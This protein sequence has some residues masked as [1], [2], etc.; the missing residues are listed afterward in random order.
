MKRS[1]PRIALAAIALMALPAA[2][3][4]QE[5]PDYVDSSRAWHA[6][7]F[8]ENG[9]RVCYVASRPEREEGNYTRRGD[10]FVLVTHRPAEGSRDVVS[11]YAGYPFGEEQN[12][13]A[14]VDG[15]R[16]F[17]LFTEGE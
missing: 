2:G 6:F 11:F 3:Q 13:T 1:S 12:A 7:Q 15:G 5:R 14:T 9:S 17:P 16:A 10:V 8:E 4:A